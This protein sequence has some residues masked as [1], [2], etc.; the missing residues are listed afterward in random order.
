MSVKTVGFLPF[1][2]FLILFFGVSQVMSILVLKDIVPYDMQTLFDFGGLQENFTI[3]HIIYTSAALAA[4]L[5]L[6]G[7]F[8]AL[9]SLDL[10]GTLRGVLNTGKSSRFLWSLIAILLCSVHVILYLLV[11][12]WDQ[13]WLYDTYLSVGTDAKWVGIFGDRFS[14]A[15]IKAGPAFAILSCLCACAL[16]RTRHTILKF[17]AGALTVFYF[18]ILLSQHSRASAFFPLLL[19]INFALLRLK[20]R[21]V[22]IPIL[23]F[24]AAISF[25]GALVGRGTDRHGLS[26]LP[27]TIISP[28][29]SSDPLYAISQAL[30]DSC[31]GIIVTMESLQVTG[32]FDPLYKFLAFSPLP[33]FIDNYSSIRE[34]REHR[35]HDYVPMSG[36]GELFHFGWFYVSLLLIGYIFLIR[37]HTKIADKNPAIF[38]LCN[39]LIAMSLYILFAYPLR[40]AL[41]FYWIAVALAVIADFTRRRSTKTKHSTLRLRDEPPSR[42]AHSSDPSRSILSK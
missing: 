30:M 5:S 34:E 38:I 41:R 8:R 24:V 11:S 13:L 22:V 18:A 32:D 33:S 36:V 20:G 35:L 23:V 3:V 29:V 39:L 15:I 26:A 16:T 19:A 6:S 9:R 21:M 31:Q 1:P 28:F 37:A 25:L 40:N 12:D 4:L 17:F 7:K 27:E 2:T 10:A 14:D 42:T